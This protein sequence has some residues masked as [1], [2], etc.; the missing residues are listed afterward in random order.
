MGPYFLNVSVLED[1]DEVGVSD[2]GEAVGDDDGGAADSGLVEGF[3]DE[4]FGFGIEGAGGF[5]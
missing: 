4:P 3:L 2:G 5:I 1:G